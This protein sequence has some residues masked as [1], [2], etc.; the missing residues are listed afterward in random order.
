[1]QTFLRLLFVLFT[2]ITLLTLASLGAPAFAEE[3]PVAL[4][5]RGQLHRAAAV[6]ERRLAAGDDATAAWVLARIR[7]DQD[8]AAEAQKLAETAVRLA[9]R[10]ADAHETLG[11]AC[12]SR[13]QHASVFQQPG[14]A[15]RCRKEAEAALQLDPRHVEAHLLL[16][17]FHLAAPGI[18]GGDR[19]KAAA[20]ADDLVRID[21][22]RGW[23][24][25][26]T[27]ARK[28]DSTQVESCYQRGVEAAPGSARARI[29]LA[30][31]W[32]TPGHEHFDRAETLA[33]EAVALEPW[34]TGGWS[35][36]AGI[37]A[38]QSRWTE[39]DGVL[40]KAEAQLPDTRLPAYV[41]ARTLI[42]EHREPER[43]IRLLRHYLEAEP[44]IGAP[45]PAAAH[46]RIALA[47]EQMGH[48]DEAVAELKTAVN[49]QP[50]FQEAKADLKR[51]SR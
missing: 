41:A 42:N 1:M 5:D 37:D 24:A 32:V 6:C 48:K 47:L 23:I 29:A 38:H 2:L 3:D 49:L 39:L 11:E 43:A 15:G 4:F 26:A 19:K 44:E 34:R 35:L 36:L 28:L 18:M 40:A 9:P 31:W 30:S 22:A 16:I 7:M 10:S 17:Q 51:L 45:R 12:G 33:N 8:R 21:P 20:L 46:W 27:V 13:A 14:L 25:K 50:D